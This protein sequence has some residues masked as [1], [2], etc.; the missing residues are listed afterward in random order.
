MPFWDFLRLG[1][2]QGDRGLFATPKHSLA[3]FIDGC[4][5]RTNKTTLFVLYLSASFY[6]CL[7]EFEFKKCCNTV[8]Q[9]FGFRCSLPPLTRSLKLQR[10]LLVEKN[11]Y[12]LS[13]LSLLIIVYLKNMA[14]KLNFVWVRRSCSTRSLISL[15]YDKI[16]RSLPLHFRG[17]SIS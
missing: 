1:S 16:I 7:L 6:S 11:N 3:C 9:T 8:T 17:D 15:F 13:V 12:T 2:P 10:I 4:L 14:L 5:E